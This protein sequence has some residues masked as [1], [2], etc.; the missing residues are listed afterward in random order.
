[1]NGSNKQVPWFKVYKEFYIGSDSTAVHFLKS[2]LLIQCQEGFEV[3]DPERLSDVQL[4][5]PD[6]E[7]KSREF[8]FIKEA[9]ALPLGIFRL[10]EHF[11]LC[12]DQFAFM[13]TTHG[14]LVKH[15]YKR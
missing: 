13:V 5:L 10:G 15:K 9:E 1:M 7:Q 14:E 8:R 11:L 2:K 12:Y 3:I 6:C 4:N